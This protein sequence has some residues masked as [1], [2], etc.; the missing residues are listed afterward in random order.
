MTQ[1]TTATPSRP[2]ERTELEEG[3]QVLAAAFAREAFWNYVLTD[4]TRRVE[5]LLPTYR[6][7]L[8][9]GFERGRVTTL[10]AV[11]AV[12]IWLPHQHADPSFMSEVRLGGL[13]VLLAQGP[14]AIARLLRVSDYMARLRERLTGGEH[15]YLWAL[16]VR[17]GLQG[18]G[19]GSRL[20][21]AGLEALDRER[22][23]TYLETHDAPNVPFY[24]RHG[25][26][27][28]DEE[29]VPRTPLKQWSMLRRPP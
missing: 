14:A 8:R 15:E 3:A 25:F 11:D 9:Y 2:L 12:A 27:L 1:D 23:T 10:G 24:E 17:P 4:A 18:Q 6:L 29:V 28:L 21:R 16:G 19:L 13:A 7:M 20:L 5:R 26:A 22:R